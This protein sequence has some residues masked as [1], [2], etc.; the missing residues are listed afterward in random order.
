AIDDPG[1]LRD[2][3]SRDRRVYSEPPHQRDQD[4]RVRGIEHTDS[5]EEVGRFQHGP[6]TQV[7]DVVRAADIVDD[8]VC[9]EFLE[10]ARERATNLGFLRRREAAAAPQELEAETPLRIAV[11]LLRG[12]PR[13]QDVQPYCAI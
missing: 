12:L 9:G 4:L 8:R 11:H 1:L 10:G 5:A 3:R 13:E 6:G 2:E 7:V